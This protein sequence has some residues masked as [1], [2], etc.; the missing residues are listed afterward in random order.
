MVN[1]LDFWYPLPGW[2]EAEDYSSQVG[3]ELETTTDVGGGQNVGFLDPGDVLEYLVHVTQT[4]EYK[5]H[6]R[7]ASEYGNGG[8]SM[9]LIDDFGQST[10]LCQANF[11]PT[12]GW[13]E[14]HHDGDIVH[15]TVFTPCG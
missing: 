7:T 13:Q 8:L 10:Y 12:G 6:F 15:M 2:L 9:E 11:E 4:G 5:V 3:V 14:D 1:D